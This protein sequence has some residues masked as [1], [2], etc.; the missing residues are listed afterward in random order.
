ML[1]GPTLQFRQQDA[2]AQGAV[3][4]ARRCGELDGVGIDRGEQSR[5]AERR[6]LPAA[7]DQDAGAGPTRGK[8]ARR[9][10]DQSLRSVRRRGMRSGPRRR[11]RSG[12]GEAVAAGAGV[13]RAPHRQARQRGRWR[14][15]RRLAGRASTGV[16]CRRS[17]GEAVAVGTRRC[18]T[19]GWDRGTR[20]ADLTTL[21]RGRCRTRRRQAT[22]SPGITL[23]G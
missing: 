18:T 19:S 5:C 20:D 22:K 3:F 11:W 8:P 12:R 10:S 23:F 1:S 13:G 21:P 4:L 17:D 14:T 15:G 16:G 6:G 2:D 7:R 9:L